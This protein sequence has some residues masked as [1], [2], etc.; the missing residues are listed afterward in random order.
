[1]AIG[2]KSV[3]GKI[4][5]PLIN[6]LEPP[7][8]LH[9]GSLSPHFTLRGHDGQ[10]VSTHD[11]A[12]NFSFVLVFYPGDDT[13]TCSEQ[14]A[15][16]NA[17]LDEFTAASVKV[18]GVNQAGTESHR[19]FARKLNLSFPL[20]V[21]DGL[22][23]AQAW[24]AARKGVPLTYRT[25][26]LVDKQRVVRFAERGK[27]DVET[28]LSLAT[29][30]GNRGFRDDEAKLAKEEGLSYT[31]DITPAKALRM[32]KELPEYLLVDIRPGWEY[33]EGHLAQAYNIPVDD[34][35][36]RLAELG[37]KTRPVF[38][39]DNKG[40]AGGGAAQYI[41]GLGYQSVYHIGGGM[42]YWEEKMGTKN[43]IKGPGPGWKGNDA[44]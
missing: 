43:L 16:F 32:W 20:L 2:F 18:F 14:L 27:P 1:M 23:V 10:Q 21:D 24:W 40:I 3:L 28:V 5:R 26:Y 11:L 6:A 8:P 39:L 29:T 41:F 12:G 19:N 22:Q 25:V 38:V 31:D 34:L 33:A 13:P 15:E 44:Y 17:R 30:A 7:F 36:K 4:A 9:V 35:P 42:Y 37:P